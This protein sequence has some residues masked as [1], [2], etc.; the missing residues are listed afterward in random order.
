MVISSITV[1]LAMW[2]LSAADMCVVA[3][4]ITLV[5]SFQYQLQP[6]IRHWI[7]KGLN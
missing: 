3:I 5:H 2:V 6:I 4:Q 7:G 1:E